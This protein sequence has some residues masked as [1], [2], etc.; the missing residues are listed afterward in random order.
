MHREVFA[1]L[2]T[3]TELD[4]PP[5]QK[6]NDKGL[7]HMKQLFG[8]RKVTLTMYRCMRIQTVHILLYQHII[9]IILLYQDSIPIL[10]HHVSE[11]FTQLLCIYIKCYKRQHF[12]DQSIF[13]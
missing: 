1:L 7:R 13:C 8:N 9:H 4:P 6:T 11:K 3:G 12:Q 5:I 10:Y 2:G